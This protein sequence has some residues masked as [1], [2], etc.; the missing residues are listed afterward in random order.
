MND[1]SH[2][3]TELRL[4]ESTNLDAMSIDRSARVTGVHASAL[5]PATGYYSPSDNFVA[6]L[7]FDDGS[8]ATLTY[9]ALGSADFPKETMDVFV[10]G[11]VVTLDDYRAVA[12]VGAKRRRRPS[13]APDKGHK[14]ELAAFAQAVKGAAD[15]PIPLWQQLQSARIALEVERFLTPRG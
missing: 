7:A 9:T 8:V 12:V 10:D 5:R 2:L 4:T 6:T 13:H 14:S 11:L 3:L 15:W 1:R